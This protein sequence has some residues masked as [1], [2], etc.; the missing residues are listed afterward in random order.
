MPVK[1]SELVTE[2][3]KTSI[4]DTVVAKIAGI[5]CREVAGVHDMGGGAAR[6]MGAIKEMLPIGSDAPSPTRGVSVEVGERQSAVDLD[7]VIDY[8]AAIVDVAASIRDNVIDRLESMTGLEVMEVN[9][10]V[11]DVYLGEDESRSNGAES[12]VQ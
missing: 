12:R 1:R 6:T 2:Q 8:G 10:T 11:D 4:A 3:G 9:V 7:V 5:A